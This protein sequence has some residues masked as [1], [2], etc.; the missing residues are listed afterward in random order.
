MDTQTIR[1]REKDKTQVVRASISKSVF[2]EICPVCTE[3]AEDL[4]ALTIMETKERWSGTGSL[5]SAWVQPQDKAELS[6]SDARGGITFWIPTCMMHGS[7]SVSS[8]KKKVLSI[9]GFM[10]LF[11]PLLYFALGTLTALQ[12]SRPIEASVIPFFAMGIFIAL[13][14]IYGFYP[15]AL[16]RKIRFLGINRAKDETLILLRNAVYRKLFLE[17]N[18]MHAALLEKMKTDGKEQDSLGGK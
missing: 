2:P 14:L 4:V 18:P 6:L 8:P 16:E 3:D 10:I 1:I 7:S 12:Y 15:R 11:Y 5:A 13:D 9:V 17:K